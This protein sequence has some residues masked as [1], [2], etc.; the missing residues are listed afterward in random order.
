M[1]A[2]VE[3]I[4]QAA[5][6]RQR[7]VAKSAVAKAVAE[8]RI[9]LIDG[10]IDPAVADIQWEKNTR[11][12]ADS[13]RAGAT[14]AE[15]EG[16]GGPAAETAPVVAEAPPAAP[17]YNE[18][19][20][21]REK[22]EA[23]KSE[24]EAARLA[25]RLIDRDTTERAIFDAFRQLRDAVMTSAQRAAPKLLGLADVREVERVIEDEQ[26]KAFAGWEQRMLERLPSKEAV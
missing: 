21:R 22:A 8:G 20:T 15:V 2:R 11:A 17:G 10:K 12:R 4:T 3:L 25:G 6:A 24:F 13:R 9:S 5:Y 19:R 18:F 23:E 7:G 1:N 16:A 26:R 14:S